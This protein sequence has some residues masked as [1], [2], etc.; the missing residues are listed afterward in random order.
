MAVDPPED[1]QAEVV[2]DAQSEAPGEGPAEAAAAG[3]TAQGLGPG[4][5]MRIVHDPVAQGKPQRHKVE[6]DDALKY[7][8]KVRHGPGTQQRRPRPHASSGGRRE[9][10]RPTP[11][12]A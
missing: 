10:R 4:A 9:L 3:P 2:P 1:P 8:E 7:L 12:R 6:V 5:G 11:R